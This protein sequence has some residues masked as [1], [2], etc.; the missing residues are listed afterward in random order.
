MNQKPPYSQ[1]TWPKFAL[2]TEADERPE[3]VKA[4]FLLV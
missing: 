2:Q 3:V 4:E 1:H